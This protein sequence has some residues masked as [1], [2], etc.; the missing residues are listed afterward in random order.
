MLYLIQKQSLLKRQK[1]LP[2]PSKQQVYRREIET[3]VQGKTVIEKM[4]FQSDLNT[5]SEKSNS[6]GR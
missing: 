6:I 5:N 3:G 1:G 2:R 4:L